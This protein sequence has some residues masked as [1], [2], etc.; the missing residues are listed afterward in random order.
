[1]FLITKTYQTSVPTT[2][3][4]SD[5]R[6]P[7]LQTEAWLTEVELDSAGQGKHR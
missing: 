2:K 3:T 6:S 1:M 4:P 5:Q 7:V